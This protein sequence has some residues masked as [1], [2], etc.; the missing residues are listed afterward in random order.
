MRNDP[1]VELKDRLCWEVDTATRAAGLERKAGGLRDLH[2]QMRDVAKT[3]RRCIEIRDEA[4]VEI[5]RLAAIPKEP[6]ME[7]QI[8]TMRK[9]LNLLKAERSTT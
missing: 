5:T 1:L 8:A 4:L 2:V 9:E 3:E 7:E 6:T